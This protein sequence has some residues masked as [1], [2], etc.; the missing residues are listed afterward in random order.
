[1]LRT[2]EEYQKLDWKAHVPTLV[3]AYIATIDD[4]TGYSPYFLMFP[5]HPCLSIDAFLVLSPDP[6]SAKQ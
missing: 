4:S 2:L 6:L 1:M 3:H 5:R